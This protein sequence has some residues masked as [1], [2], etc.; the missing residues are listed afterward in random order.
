MTVRE[1]IVGQT[2]TLNDNR[3]TVVGVMPEGF[4]YPNAD[5][6]IW[7]PMAFSPSEKTVRDTNYLS[8][9]ARLKQGVTLGQ[10]SVQMNLLAQQIAQQH[11]ELNIQR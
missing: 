6:Q 10:A 2:L 9:I 5:I 8:I 3:F 1:R 4:T 11:P 7:T